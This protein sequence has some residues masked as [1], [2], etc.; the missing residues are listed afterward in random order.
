MPYKYILTAVSSVGDAHQKSDEFY[1]A[2][3]LTSVIKNA[4]NS[5]RTRNI[6]KGRKH[7]FSVISCRERFSMLCDYLYHALMKRNNDKVRIKVQYALRAITDEIYAMTGKEDDAHMSMLYID[8][9][10]IYVSGFGDTHIYHISK[11]SSNATK[12]TFQLTTLSDAIRVEGEDSDPDEHSV[13]TWSKC[14][15]ELNAKDE[16]LIVGSHLK[17]LLGDDAV[18]DVLSASHIDSPSVL[19][20]KAHLLDSSRT[21]SALHI[22]VKKTF[23]MLWISLG[24]SLFAIA[25]A[26]FFLI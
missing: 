1:F 3:G 24:A 13:N 26:L 18:C 17:S 8:G 14:L 12:V 9:S 15:G 6:C 22:I 10:N 19:V 4:C 16:Y 23:P 11:N 2:D 25:L 7:I 20:D 5:V 21:V